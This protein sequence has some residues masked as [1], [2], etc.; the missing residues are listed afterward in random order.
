VA[1][2]KTNVPPPVNPTVPAPSDEPHANPVA[3]EGEA[4]RRQP[5]TNQPFPTTG[6][7]PPQPPAK[8]L[9]QK[10]PPPLI[11]DRMAEVEQPAPRSDRMA[12]EPSGRSQGP[13]GPDLQTATAITRQ[14]TAAIVSHS[15]QSTQIRL[16]PAELGHVTMD[17][18]D[19]DGQ[20]HI[21]ITLEK[22]E[23]ADL[24]RRTAELLT[25]EFQREGFSGTSLSFADQRE[26]GQ[27]ASQG[28]HEVHLPIL[29]H[30][31]TAP[32]LPLTSGRLD[33]RL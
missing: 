10:D 5:Q 8:D 7:A 18:Q 21:T 9:V 22:P 25:R 11:L 26:Q 3:A 14:M 23:T 16:D 28:G 17:V 31:A 33:L 19:V 32:P 6:P 13:T 29:E 24:M 20:L 12:A 27:R 15:P 4:E 30:E 1:E 2:Q